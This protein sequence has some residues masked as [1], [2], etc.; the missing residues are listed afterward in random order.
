MIR[1]LA[2]CVQYTL[3]RC[4]ESKFTYNA[5]EKYNIYIAVQKSESK[6]AIYFR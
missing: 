6:N 2:K 5:Y 3:T 4:E 1:S